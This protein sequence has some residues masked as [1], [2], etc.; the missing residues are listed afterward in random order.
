MLLME[1]QDFLDL[2][3]KCSVSLFNAKYIFVEQT[4]VPNTTC[5]TFH[6]YKL[7]WNS[8]HV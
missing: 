7:D 4:Q 5:I 3:V 2:L 6:Y 1:P 8:V